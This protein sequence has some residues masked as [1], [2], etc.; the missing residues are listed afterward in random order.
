VAVQ[1][2]TLSTARTTALT[3]TPENGQWKITGYDVSVTRQG[4]QVEGATT[5]TAVKK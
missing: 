4:A 1:G 3:F 2:G 5:T